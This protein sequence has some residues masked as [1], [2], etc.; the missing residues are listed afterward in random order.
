MVNMGD[1]LS[2]NPRIL[3]VDDD[4]D[5]RLTLCEYLETCNFAVSSTCNGCEA[6][7]PLAA[8]KSVSIDS[9][10]VKIEALLCTLLAKAGA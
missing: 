3:I 9:R 2:S 1:G 7:T 5:L 8:E 10:L 4:D 6:I